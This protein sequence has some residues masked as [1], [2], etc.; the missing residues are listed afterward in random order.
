MLTGAGLGEGLGGLGLGLGLRVEL[1]A[2]LGMHF[3]LEGSS[4]LSCPGGHGGR[5]AQDTASRERC[6][7]FFYGEG[8]GLLKVDTCTAGRYCPQL[9]GGWGTEG[10][11]EG[12]ESSQA[13]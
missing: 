12:E 9:V 2:Q 13:R 1:M 11:T 6:I 8:G 3:Q 5:S 7:V 4:L 10:G